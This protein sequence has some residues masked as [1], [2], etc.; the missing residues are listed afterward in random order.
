ME[1][2]APRTQLRKARVKLSPPQQRM[3]IE[4]LPY[5]A[6]KLSATAITTMN[7]QS[8][9]EALDRCIARSKAP[10]ALNSPTVIEHEPVV[11]ASE[12][13]RPFSRYRRY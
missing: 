4:M 8:F 11:E 7:G 3:L 13:K 5:I 6:P 9:A 1:I 10:L 2:L 12:M